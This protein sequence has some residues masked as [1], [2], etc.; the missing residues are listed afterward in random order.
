MNPT[1]EI[2]PIYEAFVNRKG[3]VGKTTISLQRAFDHA[4]KGRKT[5]LVDLDPQ[6]NASFRSLKPNEMGMPT[7]D[8][9]ASFMLFDQSFSSSGELKA[10]SSHENLT[11][12]YS[13]LNDQ[14]LESIDENHANIQFFLAALD[15]FVFSNGFEAVVIDAPPSAGRLQTAA[16]AIGGNIYVPSEIYISENVGSIHQFIKK[17]VAS[18]PGSTSKFR[19]VI[20]NKFSKK[21]QNEQD[22]LD[23]VFEELGSKCLADVIRDRLDIRRA[24][25]DGISIFEQKPVNKGTVEMFRNLFRTMDAKSGFPEFKVSK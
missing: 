25:D 9:V 6:G 23:G 16:I 22:L 3:G 1:N 18:I 4:L 15:E 10:N 2:E 20:I 13:R 21:S 11:T 17:A 14:Y 7:Y 8:G 5:C 12:I 19:G 24:T